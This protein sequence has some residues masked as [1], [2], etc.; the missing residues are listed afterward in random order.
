M[1]LGKKSS[2][3]NI[4]LALLAS[5][6]IS[7]VLFT[8]RA[9][10]SHSNRYWFLVWNLALAW[11]PLMFAWWLK[12]RLKKTSWATWRNVVLSLLWLSFLPNSFYLV[13]DFVHLHPTGEVSVLFDSV[14]FMSFAWNGLVLGFA[15]VIIVHLELIKRLRQRLV[16]L[17]LGLAFLLCSFAIYLGRYLGWNTWDILVNPV[18]ILFDLSDRIV[19]PTSYPNT[20]TTTSMFF[21]LLTT[22]YYTTYRLF[23]AVRVDHKVERL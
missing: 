4:V 1:I 6:K 13:S 5:T 8:C 3:D 11:L 10:S 12:T 14:M 23:S 9:L 17:L 15:S 7:L 19:R 18:G 21:V 20:F 2:A 22:T 16:L